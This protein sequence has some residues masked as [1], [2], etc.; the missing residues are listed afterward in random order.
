MSMSLISLLVFPLLQTH[1]Q[2]ANMVI[3]ERKT[4]PNYTFLIC[5]GG[6]NNV[7][8]EKKN[9]ELAAVRTHFDLTLSILLPI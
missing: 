8:V 7:L 9:T 3:N 2:S 6:N 4:E 5:L 1:K